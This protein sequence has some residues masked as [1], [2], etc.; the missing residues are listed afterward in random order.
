M[1]MSHNQEAIK[2]RLLVHIVKTKKPVK[3]FD[4]TK[5]KTKITI[6][7]HFLKKLAHTYNVNTSASWNQNCNLKINSKKRKT[8]WVNW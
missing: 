6:Y 1:L 3:V 2:T 8:Y 7:A 5:I 4:E